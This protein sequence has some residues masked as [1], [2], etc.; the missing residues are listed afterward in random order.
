MSARAVGLCV[1]LAV[2]LGC[3]STPPVQPLLNQAKLNAKAREYEA[4]HDLARQAAMANPSDEEARAAF[5]LGAFCHQKLYFRDRPVG[6]FVKDSPW[7]STK[8]AGQFEWAASFFDGETYPEAVVDELLI[9]Y[10]YGVFAQWKEF[11]AAKPQ[12]AGYRM[13]VR[14]DN[15]IVEKVSIGDEPGLR[16]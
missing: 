12:L 1:G 11:A 5:R 13:R 7:P 15:G 3:A 8:L 2:V 4:C 14:V 10:P 16:D 9:G 6:D